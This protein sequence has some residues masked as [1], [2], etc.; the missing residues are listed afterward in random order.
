MTKSALKTTHFKLKFLFCSFLRKQRSLHF[1]L[2]NCLKAKRQMRNYWFCSKRG[3]LVVKLGQNIFAPK[4]QWKEYK[5]LFDCVKVGDARWIRNFQARLTVWQ[6]ERL[7]SW[8]E[9][10]ETLA[11]WPRDFLDRP[12][13]TTATASVMTRCETT[14]RSTRHRDATGASDPA[15]FKY[16]CTYIH[17]DSF[18]FFCDM[19]C[20]TFDL[21]Q[22]SFGQT[23]KGLQFM[24]W[25]RDCRENKWILISFCFIQNY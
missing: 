19:T 4:R 13:V 12:S 7:R 14:E 17:C 20:C 23:E 21:R 25:V 1:S 3:A 11:C 9:W 22:F 24:C 5:L 8:S 10:R 6:L 15:P 16:G 18:T 2:D